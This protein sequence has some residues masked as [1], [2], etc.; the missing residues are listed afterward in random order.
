MELRHE[1][2]HDLLSV[3]ALLVTAVLVDGLRNALQPD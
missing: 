3:D 1:L 2:L